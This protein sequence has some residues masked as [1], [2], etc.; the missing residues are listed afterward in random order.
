MSNEEFEQRFAKLTEQVNELSLENKSDLEQLI[1]ETRQRRVEVVKT[2]EGI[3]TTLQ[4]L[5]L[6]IKYIVFDNEATQREN[7]ALRKL[8][9]STDGE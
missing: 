7:I 6:A 8:L 1:E 4:D 5:K 2:M 9:E 3:D